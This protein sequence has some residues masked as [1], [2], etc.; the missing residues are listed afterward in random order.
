MKLRK[1]AAAGLVL[2]L[3]LSLGAPAFAAEAADA[4]LTKVTL[5]VK[6]TLDIDDS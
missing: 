4:R 5:A 3:G 2:A 6:G 1:L